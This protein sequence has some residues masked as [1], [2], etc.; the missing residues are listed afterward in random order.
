MSLR[1]CG[2][3]RRFPPFVAR[4][5]LSSVPE[6]T[7]KLPSAGKAWQ[8]KPWQRNFLRGILIGAV[9]TPAWMI[10]DNYRRGSSFVQYRLVKKEPVS[11]T[12]SIFY[13]EPESGSRCRECEKHGWPAIISNFQFKQ[14]QI[15]IVRAYTPLPPT[16]DGENGGVLRFLIRREHEGEVSNYIHS[17]PLGAKVELRGPNIEYM[18]PQD[19][20]EVVFVAGGTGIAP[21]LQVAHA[22][23]DR[24]FP[25]HVRFEQDKRKLLILWANRR[26]EDCVGG[27][28]QP[29]SIPAAT[30]PA[31]GFLKSISRWVRPD[32]MPDLPP[33]TQETHN[34]GL[35]VSELE[36]LAAAHPGQISVQYFVN[37]ED[38]WINARALDQALNIFDDDHVSREAR[39]TQERRQI[40]I[41][42]PPGFITHIAGSKEWRN[43]R[44]EQGA[45][46]HLLAHALSQNPHN[47]KIWKV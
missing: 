22:M 43:G 23:F 2:P 10:Y 20:K 30:T 32:P 16:Q 1:S 3:N 37:E 12:A 26:R 31:A 19:V 25:G 28:I 41:S 27:G 45:V 42:G 38:T 7:R 24:P 11:S 5:H 17:L 46:S 47:V 15:Q 39:N 13:L 29:S 18:L 21:A 35:I 33:A 9:L 40:I 44:E 34:K 14:P 6:R 8:W 36:A 4:T